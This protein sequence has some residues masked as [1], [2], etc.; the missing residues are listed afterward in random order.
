MCKGHSSRDSDRVRGDVERGRR[1]E[2]RVEERGGRESENGLLG[3]TAECRSLKRK[4]EGGNKSRQN[5]S[6]YPVEFY[7]ISRHLLR[8]GETKGGREHTPPGI[9]Y[10]PVVSL[11]ANYPIQGIPHSSSV[12]SVNTR[13][14]SK[15]ES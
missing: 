1:R 6:L 3:S 7:W 13:V 12:V 10:S 8:K 4:R 11:N 9:I 5:A 14:Q 2:E 15:G